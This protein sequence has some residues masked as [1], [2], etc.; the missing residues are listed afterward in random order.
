MVPHDLMGVQ[1]TKISVYF[2]FTRCTFFTRIGPSSVC[3]CLPDPPGPEHQPPY[4][5]QRGPGVRHRHGGQLHDARAGLPRGH[6]ALRRLRLSLR[7]R[8]RGLLPG[9]RHR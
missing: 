2:F 6:P 9:L 4:R 1:I 8:G 7:H 3:L 5:A